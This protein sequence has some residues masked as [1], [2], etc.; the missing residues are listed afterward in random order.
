MMERLYEVVVG[1]AV[2]ARDALADLRACRGDNDRRRLLCS[3]Q[4]RDDLPA[5]PVGQAEINDIEGVPEGLGHLLEFGQ[6]SCEIDRIPRVVQMLPEQ[7]SSPDVILDQQYAH[8]LP[9]LPRFSGRPP[10]ERH[11]TPRH[12]SQFMRRPLSEVQLIVDSA[13]GC[14]QLLHL[15]TTTSGKRHHFLKVVVPNA[16]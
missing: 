12:S 9:P 4:K 10:W 1:T 7:R 6:G 2:K 14:C 13:S 8:T 5:V 3:P 15:P 11:T 16:S